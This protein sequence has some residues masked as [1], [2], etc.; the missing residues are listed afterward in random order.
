VV[1]LDPQALTDLSHPRTDLPLLKPQKVDVRKALESVAIVTPDINLPETHDAS[2]A[3][4]GRLSRLYGRY[5]SQITAR[6]ERAWVRPRTAIGAP[7]FS[8]KVQLL[9]D[10]SGNVKEVTLVDC[11]GDSRWQVSLVRAIQ[12]AS[13]L[14][15]PPD[16][17]VFS[18]T[19]VLGFNAEEF[20]H[21]GSTDGYER[22]VTASAVLH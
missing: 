2:V 13:P 10:T 14:P 8:C 3:D 19:L 12:S 9:Q 15:A 22:A 7:S 21:S 6:I 5:V 16:S 11:N 17:D 4:A 20:S 1:A 18:R